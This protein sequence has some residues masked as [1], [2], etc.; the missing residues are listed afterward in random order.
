MEINIVGGVYY[1]NCISPQ[2][3]EFYG[4]GLRSAISLSSSIDRI[5]LHSLKSDAAEGQL[6]CLSTSYNN[7]TCNLIK[8]PSL[9]SFYYYHPLSVPEISPHP[10]SIEEKPLIKV[11]G[12]NIIQFGMLDANVK[13]DGCR[14]VYDLQSIW[15]P[16]S[17][18]KQ[19]SKCED[20]I[21]IGNSTE[22][23]KL[24]SASDIIEAGKN[25][26]Q[27]ENAAY[28][29]IKRGA[30]GGYVVSLDDCSSF[31][32]YKSKTVFP[33]GS[34]DIFTSVFSYYWFNGH[35]P[36]EAAQK[37]S[38]ATAFYVENIYLPLDLQQIA[39]IPYE[40]LKAKEEKKQIYLAGPFFNL[41][42]R[43]MIEESYR[44]LKSQTIDVFSPIHKVGRGDADKVVRKDLEG[45]NTSDVL[46]AIV[47]NLDS[48]TIFEIGYAVAKGI[49]VIAFSQKEAK[50]DLKMLYGSK[51]EIYDDYSTAIYK[52]IWRALEK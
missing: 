33:I 14:V 25:I 22:I 20:L 44:N 40:E 39:I 19:G 8:V 29:I 38:K 42:E 9:L 48:G 34:G 11:S 31:G 27:K 50:E 37:A 18:I 24:G 43:W 30:L 51:C 23:K 15:N 1:E 21:I 36:V 41:N 3:N 47:D 52:T 13:A 7:V 26:C 10:L 28:V 16:R 17:F 6:Q 32:A 2:S 46:F 45:L 4:S 49:P 5:K 12:D 35:S